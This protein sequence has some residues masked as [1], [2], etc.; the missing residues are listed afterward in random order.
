MD[1]SGVITQLRISVLQDSIMEQIQQV[2]ELENLEEVCSF[3]TEASS[4][5]L[6]MN[7]LRLG[8]KYLQELTKIFCRDISFGDFSFYCS[9]G[10]AIEICLLSL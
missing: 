5:I 1:I 7:G 8:N 4:D 3:Y 9:R 2:M 10:K 6:D